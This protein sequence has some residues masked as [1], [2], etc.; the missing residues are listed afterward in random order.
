MVRLFLQPRRKVRNHGYGLADLLRHSVKKNFLAVGR[1]VIKG[2]ARDGP[3][4]DQ[5]LRCTELQ[6]AAGCVYRHRKKIVGRVEIIE[7]FAIL[8]PARHYSAV[9][10]DLPLALT[11]A[12]GHYIHLNRAGFAGH[13]REPMT[14]RGELC[15][16]SALQGQ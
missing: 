6:G 3:I 13:V 7:L 10:R 4:T 16:S 15:I 8:T 9:G 2:H 11:S 14:I 12:K 1:N 5:R